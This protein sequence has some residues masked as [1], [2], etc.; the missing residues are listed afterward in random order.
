[1]FARLPAIGP[2]V[3]L[4]VMFTGGVDTPLTVTTGKRRRNRLAAPRG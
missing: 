4:T 3:P 2:T 1:M